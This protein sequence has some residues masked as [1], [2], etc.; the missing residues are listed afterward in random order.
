VT[1]AGVAARTLFGLSVVSAMSAIVRAA[2]LTGQDVRFAES[3]RGEAQLALAAFLERGGYELWTRDTVL[4][5]AD[6]V[7]ASVLVLEASARISGRIEG[8][9]FVV[10]G[11]LFLRARGGIGGDLVVLGGGFYDSDL[12]EIVGAVSYRPNERIRVRPADGGF[13]IISEGARP[14]GSELDGTYG[15]HVPV[16][17]RVDALI[18]GWGGVVRAASVPGRPELELV[19]RYKSGPGEVEGSLRNSWYPSA[20]VRV[21]VTGSRETRTNDEWIRPRWFNSLAH[22]VAGDDARDYYRTDRIGVELELRSPEPPIWVDASDWSIVLA[23]GWEEARSLSARDVTVL[24]GDDRPA[25]EGFIPYPNPAVDDGDIYSVSLGFEWSKR[26][27]E[28]RTAF[29]IG[30]EAAHDDDL[31]GDFS[32][33]QAE[34]R[35]SARRSTAWGHVWDAFAIARVDLAGTVP[36]QRYSTLGGLGTIA[37]VPLRGLRGERLLYAEAS[38]AVPLLGMP[39]LGGLDGFVRTSAGAAWSDGEALKIDE[40]LAAGI[41]VRLWDLQMEAGVAAGAGPDPD[42]LDTT[43]YLDVRVRR[44]ARPA[45]MPPRGRGF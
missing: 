30:L 8:D 32:F 4:A 27:R 36:G 40:S 5:R 15:V 13:E 29:G 45:A 10:A 6:T 17:Q 25:T 16:Y 23:A 18:L 33:L 31:D 19:A 34:A 22:F 38:Y 42:G 44:S 28:G 3:P 7:R 39:T 41:A 21:G 37:T 24:F 20:R 26:A 12:A 1:V 2:P 11:D 14:R 9:V 35:V 43:V